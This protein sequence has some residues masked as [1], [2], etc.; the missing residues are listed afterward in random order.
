MYGR[1]GTTRAY[2]RTGV[3][4][5]KQTITFLE[6]ARPPADTRT[7]TNVPIR[8]DG[9][10]DPF[11]ATVL[12]YNLIRKLDPYHPVAVVLNCQNYY[13][14]PYTVGADIIMED[15]YPIGTNSTF[16]KWGTACNAT[17]GDCGCDNCLGGAH[18]VQDVSDRLDV[19]ARYEAWLGLW[20]KTKI[21]NPQSFN[22]EGYWSRDPTPAEEYAMALLALNHGAQ[23][24][25]SWV[26]PDSDT[27]SVAHGALAKVLTTA[28]GVTFVVGNDR[29]HRI[30]VAAS[31]DVDVAFW[32]RGRE[33]LVSVVNGGYSDVSKAVEVELPGVASVKSTLWGNVTWTLSGSKL[34]AP[35]FPA[36]GTSLVLLELS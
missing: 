25:I 33:M 2:F 13:F 18:A 20:P 24:I 36:L 11:N 6:P 35:S 8:P 19:L 31:V 16:S 14:G 28:P 17:L 27:L 4:T 29:P 30:A 10:Q 34:S 5:S 1:Q 7:Y 26:Y 23:A 3:R 15:V 32:R 9:H 21:H 12:A 22:G